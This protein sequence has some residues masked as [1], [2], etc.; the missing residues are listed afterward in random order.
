VDAKQFSELVNKAEKD[1]SFLHK[2][3]FS[4]ESLVGELKGVLDRQAIG[5][6]IAKNPSE[7]VAR[8][9]GV[10]SFCGNTCTSSCDNTCGGSCGFTTNI[11]EV[12]G[13]RNISFYSRF[14]SG[15][16]ECG[17]TCSSSCDNTCGGSC[18][19][20]TNLTEFGAF[21]AQNVRSFR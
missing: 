10:V 9:I 6:L 13:A 8:T 19:Y 21:G 7:I 1:A 14:R 3:M 11:V 18:G 17:N 16:A 12:S 20:T 4:P 15:L 2:L 5:A